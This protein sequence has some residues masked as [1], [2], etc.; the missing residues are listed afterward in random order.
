MSSPY[1]GSNIHLIQG[2]IDILKPYADYKIVLAISGGVDS[3]V[4]FNIVHKLVRCELIHINSKRGAASDSRAH[5]LHQWATE[6]GYTI[7]IH[8]SD[9]SLFTHSDIRTYKYQSIEKHVDAHTLVLVAHHLNDQIETLIL[10]SMRGYNPLGWV[11]P[12]IRDFGSGYIMRPLLSFS[13]TDL[14]HYAQQNSVF[15]IEDE[16][17]ASIVHPRNYL[18]NVILQPLLAWCPTAQAGWKKSLELFGEERQLLENLHLKLLN[19]CLTSEGYI[20]I[21]QWRALSTIEQRWVLRWWLRDK[22]YTSNTLMHW[23]D[24]LLSTKSIWHYS[25]QNNQVLWKYQGCAGID[26]IPTLDITHIEQ[27]A[28]DHLLHH[29]DSL[30]IRIPLRSDNLSSFFKQR[31]IHPVLRSRTRIILHGSEIL[32][33]YPYGMYNPE[34]TIK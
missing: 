23:Q 10:K 19:H 33:I 30:T 4:L 31:K 32:A 9:K 11:M 14:I 1:Q 3:M 26:T 18:R 27:W 34:D 25:L 8:T 29:Y 2:V 21:I 12:M 7:H 24:V 15:Y 6:R 22:R 13:K 20:S 16:D 17:N 28:R 5:T